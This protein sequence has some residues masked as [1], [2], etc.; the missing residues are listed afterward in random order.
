MEPLPWARIWPSSCFMHPLHHGRHAVLLGHVARNPKARW[1][2]ATNSSVAVPSVVSLTSA[3]TTA[4]PASA[5]ARAGASPMPE[6]PPVTSA[7]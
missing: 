3:M 6:L 2:A 1:P 7:T 5:N 4:A